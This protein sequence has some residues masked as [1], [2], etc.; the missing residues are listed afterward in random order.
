MKVAEEAIH[1]AK[2]LIVDDETK[3]S[4]LALDVLRVNGYTNIETLTDPRG[5]VALLLEWQPDLIVLDLNMP[6]LDGYQVLDLV[7]STKAED[8]YLPVLVN[9]AEDSPQ[10]RERV[11]SSG[12]VDF[13]RKPFLAPEFC[14]RISNLLKLRLQFLQLEQHNQRL[15]DEVRQRASEAQGY[16]AVVHEMHLET[17]ERLARA[18]E[19]HDNETAQ[20][21]QRVALASCLVAQALGLTEQ[22]V[23][24]MRRAAPLH[25]VGKIGIP[26]SILLKPAALTE[27]E[28]RI[29]QRHCVIGGDLL[30]GGHSELLQM[31]ERI[32]LTHHEKWDGSGY[33][34]G[35]TGEQIHIY[36]RILS[37]A[38][39]FDAL[40]HDRPYKKAWTYEAAVAEIQKQSGLAFDPAVVEAFL[41]LPPEVV[42]GLHPDLPPVTPVGEDQ[43]GL[44]EPQ[45]ATILIVDDEP[46]ICRLLEVYFGE[47]GYH[48][49]IAEN[50]EEA[51]AQAEKIKPAAIIMDVMMPIMDGL[52]AVLQLK[53]QEST[54]HI[55]VAILT[56]KESYDDLERGWVTGSDVYLTKPI[57]LWQL[58]DF[59]KA[60]V[61]DQS[62]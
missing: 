17:I 14:L 10:A 15:E 35:L 22:E 16:A 5:V 53:A 11:L 26:D 6:Y 42:Q 3:H 25:D 8:E 51:L 34:L 41:A 44:P 43:T 38:D 45:A 28:R 4:N 60:A 40:T 29:M 62:H 1:Q 37:V 21:T 18:A 30:S 56:A 59:I 13:L 46:E 12:A 9:S 57:K 54:R 58:M 23:N 48:V 50:G 20:H 33:P 36:G 19:H 49:V 55:P 39:V 52:T 24:L 2:I 7:V 27:A 31:S 32:A 61:K 47:A